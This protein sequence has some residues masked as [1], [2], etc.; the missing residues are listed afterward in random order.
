MEHRVG[1]APTECIRGNHPDVDFADPGECRMLQYV[2]SH[3][4]CSILYRDSHREVSFVA[5]K[6]V[7]WRKYPALA[8]GGLVH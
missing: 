7:V 5:R 8:D 4:I 3:C 2:L 6:A 1:V